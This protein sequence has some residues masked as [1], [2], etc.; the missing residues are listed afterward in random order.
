[1]QIADMIEMLPEDEQNF[2]FEFV[3]RLVLAWDPDFTKLTASERKA[4]EEAENGEYIDEDD[5]DWG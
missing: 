1:M 5:I 4:L 3:K 2:A